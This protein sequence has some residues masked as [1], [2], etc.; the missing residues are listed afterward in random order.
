MHYFT[1]TI[2]RRCA[3]SLFPIV[4]IISFI[5]FCYPIPSED[6][7]VLAEHDSET[8]QA[9]KAKID[10]SQFQL[11]LY[12]KCFTRFGRASDPDVMDSCV[13][14]GLYGDFGEVYEKY[15]EIEMLLF[16]GFGIAKAL[17][18][19]IGSGMLF[20]ILIDFLSPVIRRYLVWLKGS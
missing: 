7:R 12:K 8:A 14:S 15:Y 2:G 11:K 17:I 18:V 20:W 5:L 1:L 19:G 3:L 9:E 4:F 13:N 16:Y 10:Y 6:L